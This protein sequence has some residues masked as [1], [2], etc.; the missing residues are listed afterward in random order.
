M[1][2]MTMLRMLLL[3][4][5]ASFWVM[6]Q[7]V[8]AQDVADA[9]PGGRV[10]LYADPA[11]NAYRVAAPAAV[12]DRLPSA[13][14]ATIVITFLGPWAPEARDALSY[15][16]D[17]WAAQ[18]RSRVPI[19]V[20][21]T[22]GGLAPTILAEGGPM[23]VWRNFPNAP[24]ADT[25]Y[26]D[27]LANSLSGADL[28]AEADITVTFNS[29]R[30]DWY[31][32][33]DGSPSG[34]Q[35][36]FVTVALHELAHGLGLTSYAQVRDGLGSWDSPEHPGIP[37]I[38]DRFVRNSSGQRLLD[39]GPFPNRSMAL[40]G[41]LTSDNL[42]FDGAHAR[43]ANG[44]APV[45]LHAPSPWAQGASY[46]HLADTYNNTPDA[47][48]TWQLSFGEAIHAPGPILFGMLQDTGWPLTG[49]AGLT[50]QVNST[51]T[52]DDANLWDT[53]CLTSAGACTLRAAVAQANAA[54]GDDT[55]LLPAGTY[56]PGRELLIDDSVT[57]IGAGAASTIIDGGQA[58][59]ALRISGPATV[60]ISGVTIH[61]SWALTSDG[62]AILNGGGVVTIDSSAFFGNRAIGGGAIINWGSGSLLS[63]TNSTFEGNHASNGGALEN[64][65][66]ATMQINNCTINGNGAS[67]I[68]GAIANFGGTLT[69][70]GGMIG[71]HPATGNNASE[72]GAISNGGGQ[73]SGGVVTL[74]HTEVWSSHAT[75]AG[76][77]IRN[78]AQN[79]VVISS[80]LV[81]WNSSD[82]YGGGIHNDGE[83]TILN[84]RL[85][86]NQA[87]SAGG[88][89]FNQGQLTVRS[90]Q[91]GGPETGII[92]RATTG[93]GIMTGG[94]GTAL[95]DATTIIGNIA[96]AGGG[97]IA[98]WGSGT[99]SIIGGS[100]IS[101]NV[102]L[103]PNPDNPAGGGGLRNYDSGRVT[104]AASAMLGNR[105]DYGGAI[106]NSAAGVIRVQIDDAGGTLPGTSRF[107]GNTA[108]AGG[109]IWNEGALT[110]AS[111]IIGGAAAADGNRASSGAGLYNYNG[112]LS[113]RAG[114]VAFNAATQSGGG[115]VNAGAGQAVIS[116]STL[117]AN[118]AAQRGGGVVSYD[119]ATLQIGDA[120]LA[121]NTA[122]QASAI[123]NS[124]GQI[125]IARSIVAGSAT[126]GAVC[127]GAVTN[128]GD[129]LATDA[130]CGGR[131]ASLAQLG[132]GALANNGGPTP[133]H[134][135]LPGSQALDALSQC[136]LPSD[137][138]G[139]S[140]PQN[141]RCDIGA[142]EL[143]SQSAGAPAG[144]AGTVA[145]LPGAAGTA[146]GAATLTNSGGAAATITI[147][148]YPANPTGAAVIDAGGQYVDLRVV[149][150]D[151]ADTVTASF[152]YPTTVA[153]SA[154]G[155]LRLLY[156]TGSGWAAVAGSGGVAPSKSTADNLDGTV[157][158]GRFRVTFDGT[159]TPRV[160]QLTGSLFTVAPVLDTFD[161]ADGK[162]GT[163]WYGPEGLGG[164][165]IRGNQLQLFGGGPI[166]W[167]REAYGVAQEAAVTIVGADPHG[168]TQ[169]L[170]LK[171]QGGLPNWRKGAIEVRYDAEGGFV[172]VGA[173][174]PGQADW[175]SSAAFPMTLRDGDR[176]GAQVGADGR[177]RVLRN[178]ELFVEVRLTAADR[179]FFSGR[180]GSIGLCFSAGGALLDDF[181]GG[182]IAP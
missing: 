109:A 144:G 13:P 60:S 33:T 21:A 3:A 17:L 118:S 40:G 164:Y 71:G 10:R 42:Y 103:T 133:T 27:P 176:L 53:F 30:S 168:R 16:A 154:E 94:S 99:L 155:S 125:A 89:I 116:N 8:I 182:T 64:G 115:L 47:L 122:P 68:G 9:Q 161:R 139:V 2:A 86:H 29:A 1:I 126:T 38:Y 114:T 110:M 22:W 14:T 44:G 45:K 120:T 37:H 128:G 179:S 150:A 63:V 156:Y 26:A 124:G 117:S 54:Q 75:R 58:H 143:V 162:L 39:I 180:G 49:P 59:R 178:G 43:A 34:S 137:Q 62:G 78:Y 165:A 24:A 70:T 163:S 148:T 119:T 50:F 145:L 170:L 127:A 28:D 136:A 173:Y 72:G 76:G 105:A 106:H 104:I 41:L 171:V 57:L 85:F 153:G 152:Y 169:A 46:V 146:G 134:A 98:N 123:D 107:A 65:G 35:Y 81:T 160:T 135:L 83:L 95:V 32:G 151:T 51:A 175:W 100:V 66:G 111:S 149:G 177:V 88:A 87:T 69:V 129:L 82:Q 96:E 67:N 140:R 25:W 174:R 74:D 73:E 48:M 113:L 141:G 112:S 56:L 97:G 131:V 19:V 61:N 121:L 159:S 142:F 108:Q 158:G 172:Q 52:A 147:A 92:N 132:F 80:T 102:A 181:S 20:E 31:F 15:A 23:W 167:R 157:S 138:R 84:S 101:A 36:D 6:P 91:I 18:L 5:L 77:A 12:A 90:S 7:L 11:I 93:A 166:Y 55:I 4:T 130:S 79:T